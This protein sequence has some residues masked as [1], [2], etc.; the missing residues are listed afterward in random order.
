MAEKISDVVKS[1]LDGMQSISHTE[2]IVGEPA[3]L[4]DA[5]IVPVH[6]LRVGFGVATAAAGAHAEKGEGK[7]GGR[8]L[9]GGAQVD[10][11]AVIAVGAD[12][13]P[14]LLAVEGEAEGAWQRLL[15]DAPD[16]LTK[17]LDKIAE[18]VALGAGKV[19]AAVAAGR[20]KGQGQGQGQEAI[21][22]PAGG[23]TKVL[24]EEAKGE[25]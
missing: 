21:A 14:R 1:L 16:L 20:A 3:Q 10:P 22:A 24:P 25:G 5:T 11:V 8:A 6:R 7:T 19:G 15:R 9:G 17:A 13:K 12:G 4:G 2:T 23:E 18:R